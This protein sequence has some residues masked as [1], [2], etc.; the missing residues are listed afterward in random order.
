MS[1]DRCREFLEE[2]GFPPDVVQEGRAGLIRRYRE[3]V[4]QV[5]KGYPKG[6]E[7]YKG[8]LEFR[9]ILKQAQA[10]DGEVREL[11][12]RLQKMLKTSKKRLW[13]SCPSK[14]F[15]DFGYP[16]NASG[17]LLRNLK[18]ENLA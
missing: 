15:W 2:N 9:T 1:V 8:E 14:V 12:E 16:S 10:E 5:E 17:E 4:A 7:Q 11:D 18:W 3:F 13:E 6:L